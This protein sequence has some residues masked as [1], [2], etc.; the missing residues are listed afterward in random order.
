VAVYLADQKWT[1][2]TIGFVLNASGAAVWW[3]E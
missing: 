2:E 1:Q 3:L